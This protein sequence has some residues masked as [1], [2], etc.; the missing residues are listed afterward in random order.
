M[1]LD[2]ALK[3]GKPVVLILEAYFSLGPVLNLAH[4]VYLVSLK[5]PLR[6]ILVRA[7]KNELAYFQASPED[8]LGIGRPSL[9]GEEIHIMEVFR[10]LHLF[11][12]MGVRIYGQM[13]DIFL[14]QLDLIWKPTQGLLRFVFA[15]TSRGPIVLMRGH[16]EQGALAAIEL[17]CLRTRIET[18]FEMRKQLL[19]VFQGHFWSKKMPKYSRKPKS[20]QPLQA[21]KAEDL[22]TVE[23][24]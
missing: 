22:H 24:C 11:Q 1:A 12:T 18:L 19:H 21:P 5:A 23:A 17:Y 8:Y 9:Y 14:L 7:Q 15:K 6:E 4:S 20:N 16:L 10:S 13:Q 3:T 2:F